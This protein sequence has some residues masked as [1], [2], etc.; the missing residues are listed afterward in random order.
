MN[1]FDEKVHVSVP[2]YGSYL[3]VWN[4]FIKDVH[5]VRVDPL[6]C[7]LS[8]LAGIS[9]GYTAGSIKQVCDHVL[10]ERR[11][12]TIESR[13]LLLDEFVYPL[14]KTHMVHAED[15]NEMRNFED[16]ISGEQHRREKA[17]EEA[18]GAVS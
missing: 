3:K 9:T 11:K 6:F 7:N 15:W 12:A 5:Q 14:S 8:I 1:S 17:Q 2:D 10:T 18:A 4:H 16:F 13:P